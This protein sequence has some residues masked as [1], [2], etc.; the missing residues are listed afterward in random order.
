MTFWLAHNVTSNTAEGLKVY[1]VPKRKGIVIKNGFNES[2]L[3]EIDSKHEIIENRTNFL[4]V[5]MVANYT[6]KKDHMT[7]IKS[8]IRVLIKL[9]NVIFVFVGKGERQSILESY[10]PAE[11][12]DRFF[13]TGFVDDVDSYIRKADLCVL[14]T[15]TEGLSN[16]LMEY[17]AFGKP[18]IATGAGGSRE[19]I[20][21]QH[22]GILLNQGDVEGMTDWIL[23][24][25][26][27][28]EYSNRIGKNAKSYVRQYLSLEKMIES[29]NKLYD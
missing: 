21:N 4:T 16:A 11:Y 17:M 19:I 15:F 25:L 9:P 7:I 20:E 6:T 18:T 13:F 24:L 3:Q 14:S 27:D 23:K 1:E 5:L 10:I 26:Q 2:R 28:K 8:G 12:K 22:N 29:F